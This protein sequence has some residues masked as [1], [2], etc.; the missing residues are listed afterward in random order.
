[1]GA[2]WKRSWP[3]FAATVL[4]LGG[5]GVASWCHAGEGG[6]RARLERLVAAYQEAQAT[7]DHRREAVWG[8]ITEGRAWWRYAAASALLQGLSSRVSVEPGAAA[9]LWVFRENEKVIAPERYAE[10]L[11]L[12]AAT[13]REAG[14][15]EVPFTTAAFLFTFLEDRYEVA[16]E[17]ASSLLGMIYARDFKEASKKYCLLGRPEDCLEQMRAFAKAGCRHFILAPLSDPAA[18]AERAAAEILPGVRSLARRSP[19]GGVL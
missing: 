12:I 4:V 5:M 3:I 16:H 10:N 11:E 15:S 9:G 6:V 14:R 7:R 8:E 1:M 2:Q 19:I 18:F 13:A 17:K